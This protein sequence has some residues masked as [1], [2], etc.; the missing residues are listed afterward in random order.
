[1]KIFVFT[2][3]FVFC[4][5]IG[6]PAVQAAYP[7]GYVV[8][9][10]VEDVG[11]T[12]VKGW[13]YQNDQP[14]DLIITFENVDTARMITYSMT[15]R[16]ESNK[17]A[18]FTQRSD[19]KAA[20]NKKYNTQLSYSR[21]QGFLFTTDFLPVGT[22]RLKSVETQALAPKTLPILSSNKTIV[23]T[24]V[25]VY[26]EGYVDTTSSGIRGWAYSSFSPENETGPEITIAISRLDNTEA[27][28]FTLPKLKQ[29]FG[30]ME[31]TSRQDV[32]S[33][34]VNERGQDSTIS[35]QP[36]PNRIYTGFTFNYNTGALPS[37]TWIINSVLAD[38][39]PIDYG[40][41][42]PSKIIYVQ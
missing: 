13:A 42:N 16:Q 14:V 39:T 17:I 25:Q 10:Y 23:K 29:Q 21:P 26:K 19:V 9:G 11:N 36:F 15:N 7:S 32:F 40:N 41:T 24:S 1:M 31:R 2:L 20:L 30:Y 6:L 35:N 22:W 27:K 18:L 12:F 5:V 4:S 8:D 28:F 33:F 38:G 3:V 37:G 34:L